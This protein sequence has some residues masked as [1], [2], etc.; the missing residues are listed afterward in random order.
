MMGEEAKE[1]SDSEFLTD[2]MREKF[3]WGTDELPQWKNDWSMIVTLHAMVETC[4]NGAILRELERP[5]LAPIIEKLDTSNQATGKAAFAKALG[6]LSKNSIVFLQK[7]SELRNT[8]VHDV[9][10][11]KF[12]LLSHLKKLGP[13]KGGEIL[14]AINKTV[15]P[16]SLPIAPKRGIIIGVIGIMD[17]H[18]RIR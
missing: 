7:L 1:Q 15:N 11:F 9:R 14:K 18:S 13:E 4:L 5:A 2:W 17:D 16:A 12:D 8:C 10:N 6:I 3:G